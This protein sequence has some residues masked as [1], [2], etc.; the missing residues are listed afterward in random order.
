MRKVLAEILIAG[1][2]IGNGVA[3]LPKF[4]GA[5]PPPLPDMVLRWN[6]FA[7]EAQVID[8]TP[9]GGLPGA[10]IRRN[11]GPTM[12]ARALA[13]VHGAV[14]DAVN[15][16]TQTHTPY[17]LTQKAPTTASPEAAII[18]AA[19]DVLV[20]LYPEQAELIHTKRADDL[21][22]ISDGQSKLDGIS[23]GQAA[24]AAMLLARQNDGDDSPSGYVSDPSPGHWWPD[25]LHPDQTPY[26]DY[27][28]TV[29][30]FV[31]TSPEDFSAPP[32][33]ALVSLEYAQSYNEV[34][35]LGA[36]NSVTRTEDQTQIGIYWGYDGSPGLGVPPRLYNQIAQ[37]LAVQQGTSQID[38]ARLF[39]LINLA[40]ADGGI[41]AWKAKYDYNFWRPITGIRESDP[42]TGHTG[43]G[44]GNDL[45]IGDPEWVPLGAP[46]SN[47]QLSATPD[48]PPTNFTPPFPAYTSGHATFGA[49]T[50][51]SLA[52]FFGTD[53]IA[54]TF[55][56]D[57]LNGSTINYDGTV[58]PL[59]PR[60]FTSLSQAALE[61]AQSRI[62]LGIHW[63]FDRDEGISHGNRVADYIFDHFAQPLVS[64]DLN[65][66]IVGP[67]L[68]RRDED[69]Q[70]TISVTNNGPAVATDTVM[71][72]PLPEHIDFS[73]LLSDQRCTLQ[74]DTITCVA[75]IEEG[76]AVG[77]A[78][79]FDLRFTARAGLCSATASLVANADSAEG[80]PVYGNNSAA[81]P[82][83][84]GCPNPD[85]VELQVSLTGTPRIFRGNEIIYQLDV[86]NTGPAAAS[87]IVTTV[88]IG[89][90]TLAPSGNPSECTQ[91][92]GDV[93]CAGFDL[94]AGS[95]RL[96]T[97]TVAT[98]REMQCPSDVSTSASVTSPQSDYYELNN[99]T[100]DV[101]TVVECEPVS[102]V[103][104]Q[105]TTPSTHDRSAVLHTLLRAT[106]NGPATATHVRIAAELPV[107][108]TFLPSSSSPG[109]VL[110]AGS[111]ECLADTLEIGSSREFDL[112]YSI[113]ESYECG[114]SIEQRAS[115]SATEFDPAPEN[116]TTNVYATRV[117]CES[118]PQ[119][120]ENE[121]SDDSTHREIAQSHSHR[122]H[123]TTQAAMVMAYLARHHDIVVADTDTELVGHFAFASDATWVL[124]LT[125]DQLQ[126]RDRSINEVP[127]T[128]N[129]LSVICG[130]KS[131][132]HQDAQIDRMDTIMPWIVEKLSAMLQRDPVDIDAVL[133]DPASCS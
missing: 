42:G 64:T 47:P 39:A 117:T 79:T 10:G 30:P 62:Y 19:H 65:A 38:N 48:V 53:D 68:V 67:E 131:Y 31:I 111:V 59:A 57:E 100:D 16:I 26:A 32:T 102:D 110:N 127:L 9:A 95:H 74:A 104:V 112:A 18:Q 45:T 52:H 108:V 51:R 89:S 43:L 24:A 54:F 129:E 17:L 35:E 107:G 93:M 120:P 66:A 71:T 61:N 96:F 36:K 41:S 92:G 69:F 99:V 1:M 76:L 91:S 3:F 105:M 6:T 25:P 97:L 126:L 11:G 7:L 22:L 80:D 86:L 27:Y 82:V 130:M 49:A 33:P 124:S 8:H 50:F 115:L 13:M 44:D 56:S 90:L 21:A 73:P 113:M 133:H 34:K 4:V 123:G 46:A 122:G 83:F 85:Q 28:G 70:T 84:V 20:A 72:L 119:A 5:E 29:R 37:H 58:R 77:S 98:S 118:S 132:L 101:R 63:S 116:N 88:P 121:R 109:C 55:T 23:I 12:S 125:V 2:L 78:A 128:A 103:S 75:G 60:S 94:S 106:N 114:A 40:Q 15:A 81:L 14:Y 87:D